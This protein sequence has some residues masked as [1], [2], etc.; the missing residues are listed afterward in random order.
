MDLLTF[1]IF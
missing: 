1:R